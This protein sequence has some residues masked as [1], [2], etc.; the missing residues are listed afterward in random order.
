MSWIWNDRLPHSKKY[1][2]KLIRELPA[3]IDR[4]LE[5]PRYWDETF[6]DLYLDHC[7]E[8]LF[9]DPRKGLKLAELAPDL[10]EKVPKRRDRQSRLVRRELRVRSN[11]VHGGALRATG[12]LDEADE[13]YQ[14]A[15]RI[16]GNGDVSALEEA[17]LHHRLAV[18]RT[19]QRRFAESFELCQ[20]AIETHRD[21]GHD[22]FL[23]EALVILGVAYNESGR[24]E[25][26]IPCFGEALQLTKNKTSR[27]YH[28]AIH[29]LALALTGTKDRASLKSALRYIREAKRRLR[30]H[31]R[32]LPKHKLTWIEGKLHVKIVLDLH[33]ERLFRRARQGFL[34]L[35]APFEL[36]LVGLDLS[37]LLKREG[38]WPELEDLAAETFGRFRLL[39]ADTESIAALS[40]WMDAVR[41]KKLDDEVVADVRL[42]LEKRMWR[43]GSARGR[44]R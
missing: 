28:A 9:R 26:A 17:N 18:L 19:T 16:C 23:G 11:A 41:A 20:D 35:G 40:L 10:A 31:R 27:T 6:L 13:A 24:F 44:R 38:R 14:A 21:F 4:L 36:A 8:V 15:L 42:K 30:D 43:H 34:E 2:Q 33:A 37:L 22:G 1:G 29:N 32:S 7:D 5:Q 3:D 39:S 12:R 25:D